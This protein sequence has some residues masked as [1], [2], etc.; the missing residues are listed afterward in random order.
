M[1]N[2]RDCLGTKKRLEYEMIQLEQKKI[3]VLQRQEF[4]HRCT[5]SIKSEGQNSR[6]IDR[7]ES[8]NA[9]EL[10][11]NSSVWRFTGARR[12]FTAAPTTP[13]SEARDSHHH[14]SAM[15]VTASGISK[16][17]R[18]SHVQPKTGESSFLFVAPIR[19]NRKKNLSVNQMVAGNRKID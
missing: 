17:Y 16:R 2:A 19:R 13:Q 10:T 4:D 1:L 8:F 15:L 7:I 11:D 3:L 9:V 14:E 5:E 12:P 6:R 18:D